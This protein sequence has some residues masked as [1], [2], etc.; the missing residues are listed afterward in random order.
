MDYTYLAE[1]LFPQV[2]LT[3]EEL[4]ERYPA[5][6]LP[7]GA[8]VTRFAPSPTGYVHFGGIYQAVVD[9]MLAK[10]S[11]GVFTLRIEDTDGQRE[12][13]GA[14][15]A[16]IRT[17]SQYGITYDEG[18][19]LNEDGTLG[20]RGAYGPYKQSQRGDIYAVY[21][22]KLV[23]EGK[24]YPCFTTE[25]ELEAIQQA[26][27][28]A[29][30]K[31]TD[32][33]TAAAEKRAAMLAGRQ[34]T[35]EEVE[36]HL[37]AGD[38]FVIRILADGDP[39]K[40]VKFT[41]QVKGLLEV[42]E[43]DEDF[44][45]LKSDGIPTYHFAHAVDDHLMRTTHVIRGE[46]WL[47]SLP[48][49]IQLFRALGFKMPKYLHTAQILKMDEN[50]GKKK[51][52]KRDMGAKMDD[53]ARLGYAEDVVWE[54]LLTLLNSNFEEWRMQNPD[55]PVR[56]YPFSIKKMSVSGCLFDFDK[57]NDVSKNVI[58]RM[59]ADQ[60]YDQVLAWA[61]EFDP[62]FADKLATDPD[63]AKAILAIGRGGNKPRKDITVWSGV[64]DYMGFFYDDYFHVEE[65]YPETFAKADIVTALEKFIGTYD[66]NDDSTTWFNKIK[67]IAPVIGFA[68][69]MK[70]YKKDPEAYRG[71]VG[72][73]SMFLRIAVTGRMNSPD[74]YSV[75]QILGAERVIA[76]VRAM[77]DSIQ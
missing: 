23:A 31:N 2:T 5:R 17:L 77:I 57:L 22:K 28:K 10:Q 46:D 14:A 47:P 30:I 24:A 11:G 71:H 36:A 32:W 54:Y 66:Y 51:I 26:D 25:E 16:L 48:K 75:M 69:E 21:A 62:D 68:P 53:Y 18:V 15:E 29:E 9:M 72:D 12:V 43:N 33:H 63:Y 56:D 13:A 61:K 19:I 50:G 41:D 76:R 40:K 4:E 67:E 39:E 35:M 7:E 49:H 45:L 42:P 34:F 74:M 38:P 73:V 44:V 55:V 3:P 65:S 52:S 37:R 6:Q 59:T 64:K 58:S 60:V 8:K 20:E 70:L 27:K 1:L